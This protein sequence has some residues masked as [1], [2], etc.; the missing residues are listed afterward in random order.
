MLHCE[1]DF[2]RLDDFLSLMINIYVFVVSDVFVAISGFVCLR[3][4]GN[5]SKG[6]LDVC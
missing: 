6:S 4:D 3:K 1:L 2:C 5:S